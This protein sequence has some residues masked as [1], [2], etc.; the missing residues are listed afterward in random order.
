[1]KFSKESGRD[2]AEYSYGTAF[3]SESDYNEHLETV[4]IVKGFSKLFHYGGTGG[5]T[6]EQA[7]EINKIIAG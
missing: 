6:L 2:C 4:E 7:R 3:K 5:L 1:M